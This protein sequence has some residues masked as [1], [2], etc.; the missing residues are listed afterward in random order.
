VR[1]YNRGQK[2]RLPR[3]GGDRRGSPTPDH[4]VR[5]NQVR[6]PT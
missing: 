3:C 6:R 5:C 4:E 1:P 2:K